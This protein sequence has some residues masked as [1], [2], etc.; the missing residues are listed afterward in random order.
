MQG[1]SV[2]ESGGQMSRIEPAGDICLRRPRSTKG[3]R[4]DDDDDDIIEQ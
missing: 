2:V 3:C 4:A 1:N